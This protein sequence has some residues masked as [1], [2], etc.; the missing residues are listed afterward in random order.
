MCVNLPGLDAELVRH[1]LGSPQAVEALRLVDQA[2]ARIAQAAADDAGE[3]V[4]VSD[5]PF[6]NVSRVA[7]PN[8]RLRRAGLLTQT[9]EGGATRLDLARTR[10][11]AMVQHQVAHLYCADE[12]SAMAA[13][14][15]LEGERGLAAIIPRHEIFRGPGYYR[16]GDTCCCEPD[17]ARLLLAGRT[18]GGI[19]WNQGPV[20]CCGYDQ[21]TC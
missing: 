12:G 9:E 2:A 13:R 11:F 17:A 6:V 18:G 21:P 8:L 3:T 20:D 14:Q 7:R 15:A 16:S 19:G 4:I 1:G 10:A 5:G